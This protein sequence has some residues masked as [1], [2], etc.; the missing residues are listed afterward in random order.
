[1]KIN[2]PINHLEAVGEAKTDRQHEREA[3]RTLAKG[4]YFSQA[5]SDTPEA[6]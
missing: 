4:I 2:L 1:V 5:L 3:D 6:E